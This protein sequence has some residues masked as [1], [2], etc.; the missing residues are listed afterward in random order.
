MDSLY[1]ASEGIGPSG[2]QYDH[3]TDRTPFRLVFPASKCPILVAPHL[4]PLF[5]AY[6]TDRQARNKIA[7]TP[8]SIYTSSLL[9]PTLA[10]LWA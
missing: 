5:L 9:P 4:S 8:P 2:V 10:L 3:H 6:L 1:V 7:A